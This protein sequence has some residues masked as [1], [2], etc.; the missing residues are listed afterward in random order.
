MKRG[1]STAATLNIGLERAILA[2]AELGTANRISNV[3]GWQSLPDLLDW[4]E[5]E[6]KQLVQEIDHS[7]QQIS[8]PPRC[9]VSSRIRRA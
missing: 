7:I 1:V 3:G 6:I 8:T 5:P 9:S 4:P 2:R